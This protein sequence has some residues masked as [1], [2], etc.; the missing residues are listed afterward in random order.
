MQHTDEP[1]VAPVAVVEVTSPSNRRAD[2]EE[3]VRVYF[4]AGT[5]VVF[6][7]DPKVRAVTVCD[8]KGRW[9]LNEGDVI[10]HSALPDFRLNVSTLFELPKPK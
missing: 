2:I 5:D 8:R 10:T 6:L 1:L 9:H 4:A 7:V 3:K